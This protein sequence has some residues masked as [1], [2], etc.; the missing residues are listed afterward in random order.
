MGDGGGGGDDASGSKG[1]KKGKGKA[2]KG[3]GGGRTRMAESAEDAALL[4]GAL[5]VPVAL[6]PKASLLLCIYFL[7]GRGALLCGVAH[8]VPLFR[9]GGACCVS[10]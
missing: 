3:G 6:G 9:R 5:Q 8:A 7:K 1:G 4:K 10:S 2:A